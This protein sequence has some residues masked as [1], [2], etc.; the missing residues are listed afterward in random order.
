MNDFLKFKILGSGGCT[1]IPRACCNCNICNE[2]RLK[3]E[4]YKRT[5]CSLY[6]YNLNMLIDTPEDINYQL[7]RDSINNIDNILYSHWDP[8]HTLGMR[9][10]EQLRL[11]C[12]D[13]F[14][15]IY[16]SN[17]INIYA[18]K[19]VSY[20]IKA[21]KNKFGSYLDYYSSLNLCNINEISPNN[22]ITLNDIKITFIPIVSSCTSTAFVF[23]HLDKK[24]IYAP[25]DNKPF[26]NSELFRNSDI[27]ILGGYIP[28]ERF[29]NNIYIP[30]GNEI[31]NA[32]FTMDEIIEIKNKYKIK[33]VILTHL[34]ENWGKSYDDYQILKDTLKDHNIDFAYD[35]MEINI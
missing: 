33:K 10:I 15:N 2:A 17:P 31:Y 14:R 27:A 30:I 1:S 35:G 4:P 12:L 6:L 5:G 21:I 18:L 9:I 29:K 8:D 20:E 28:N 22:C 23:E 19:D 11:S 7:N 24:I 32:M 25:C 26:P 13:Y 34:E 16:C 3:G